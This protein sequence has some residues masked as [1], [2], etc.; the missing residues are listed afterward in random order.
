MGNILFFTHNSQINIFSKMV[1]I[2]R[3][4]NSIKIVKVVF[5]KKSYLFVF[6]DSYS[7]ILT[8]N[9]L[10]T[11]HM[12]G[13]QMN[14]L[15]TTLKYLPILLRQSIT[16]ITDNILANWIA[17]LYYYT[18]KNWYTT[19]EVYNNVYWKCCESNVTCPLAF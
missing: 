1:T 15:H 19:L 8:Y 18:N 6:Y 4:E 17:N 13:S 9:F 5:E 14:T 16:T 11:M 7:L 10:Y 2:Q 12:W 3:D